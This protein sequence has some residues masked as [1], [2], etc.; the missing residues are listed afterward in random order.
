MKPGTIMHPDRR[1]SKIRAALAGLRLLAITAAAT[2]AGAQDAS[3]TSTP[4]TLG[5]ATNYGLLN[6]AGDTLNL[7]GG[8]NLLSGSNIGVGAND[9]VN[10][11]GNNS[12]TGNAYE[13]SGVTTNY[14]GDTSI[15]GGLY[16][17]SMAQAISDAKS[18]STNAA[19][20]TATSGLA[21]QGASITSSAT[22]KAV[23]SLSENVLDVSTVSLTNGTI[24]FDDNGHTGAKFIINVS[25]N[26]SLNNVTIK[27]ASG[28]SASD[29][30]FN[31]DGTG[32]AV[33]ITGGTTLGTFLVPASNVTVGG[34]G[35]LT[36]ELIAGV[37]NAGK[38]YTL[39]ASSS[40]YNITSL[41]YTPRTTSVP[42][43]SSIALFGA[44]SAALALY[45]LRSQRR[46]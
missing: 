15:T 33:S 11:S 26:F 25:G 16:T 27:T 9:T 19:A 2:L 46:R 42:E 1:R 21:D 36:G 30:I 8:F 45:R 41:G 31:I 37:N 43:P 18:A 7:Q 23:T 3:A 5:T 13:D 22:I 32:K 24:T 35:G 14:S 6:G 39:Q 12:I 34:N 40:G 38:S 20:L 10:L 28:A 17:Q 4:I 44:G 29:I